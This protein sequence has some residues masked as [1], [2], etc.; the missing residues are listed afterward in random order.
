MEIQGHAFAGVAAVW[1]FGP[2]GAREGEGPTAG[3]T[4]TP[5]RHATPGAL[6]DF[7]QRFPTPLLA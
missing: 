4:S 3:C 2:E 7:A 6:W 5:L 1:A